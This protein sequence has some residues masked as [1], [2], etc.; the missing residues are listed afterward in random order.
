MT[1]PPGEPATRATTAGANARQRAGLAGL[2]RSGLLS[3]AG[4]AV[5]A[6]AGVLVVLAV[7]RNLPKDTAG[8]FFALTSVFLLAGMAARLGTGTGLVWAISRTR[9]LGQPGRV[10]ALLRVALTPVVAVS[11]LLAA[12]M[13]AGAG[14]LAEIAGASADG[15]AAVAVRVLAVL[16]PLTTL[17]DTLVAATRGHGAILPTVALDR[18]GR[19]VLQLVVVVLAAATGSVAALTTAWAAPWVLSAVLAG[20]WL[21][22]LQR[23]DAPAVPARPRE[24][25]PWRE[26]W[27]FTAPRA[28]TSVVQL[29]LQRLD[30]VLLTLLAGPAEAAIYTAATRFLVVGQVANQGL[31][32]VVEPQLSRLLAVADRSAAGAV[33]RTATG[34]L[35]LLCWPLYLLVATYADGM[36]DWFGSGYDEGTVVVLVLAGSMLVASAIGMV[37]VVL[38]MGGRTSWNLGNSMLALA[39]NVVVDVLLIP[40][41]GLLGAAIGWAAAIL[42]NN[43]LPL[44]QVWRHMGLHPFGPA[45][46]TALALSVGAFGVLPL[47]TTTVWGGGAPVALATTAVGIAL[48]LLGVRRWR[49][50][51]ELDAL[52]TLR[53]RGRGAADDP[54]IPTGPLPREVRT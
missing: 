4:S 54:D 26:F 5:S 28:V 32:S 9:A 36:L 17:S 48:F 46:G 31:T 30:I 35:V 50:T 15:D 6:V 14:A 3:L 11:L 37:D 41:L 20:W 27:S 45:L 44:Y 47:A 51:L 13:F 38:I 2:A 19:P 29:A 8:T 21:L 34:W 22:R 42:V 24:A 40:P 33:Y 52:R 53:R 12:G 16:L 18:V 23:P 43:L 49:R 1:A 25:R 10:P 39:V 7:T